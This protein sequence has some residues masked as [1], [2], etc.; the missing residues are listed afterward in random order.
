MTVTDKR[1]NF[2]KMRPTVINYRSN[3][4]FSNETFRVSLINNLSNEV[5]VNNDDGLEKFWK[6]TMDTSK[7][8]T[9]I[10]NK[11]A[12]D[13]QM[14]FMTKNLY[15]EIM[16]RS[17]LRNKYIKHKTKENRLIYIQQRNNGAL[18][19]HYCCPSKGPIIPI[20]KRLKI[21]LFRKF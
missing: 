19:P 2:K 20:L 4:D 1:K 16:A 21:H 18:L 11:Y 9:P 7:S 5:F 10:K 6:T 14:P 15:K 3:R 8:S 12:R 17:R 13:N